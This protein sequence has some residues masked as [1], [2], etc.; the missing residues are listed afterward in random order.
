MNLIGCF[1]YDCKID[2]FSMVSEIGVIIHI[3]LTPN[4]IMK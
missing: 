4:K 2:Y 1:G 3:G